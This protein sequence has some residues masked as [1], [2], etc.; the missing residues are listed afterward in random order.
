MIG[1]LAQAARHLQRNHWDAVTSA[2]IQI[3]FFLCLLKCLVDAEFFADAKDSLFV[4][5]SL[6]SENR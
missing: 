2:Y 6:G 3:V 5:Y 1:K 4:R